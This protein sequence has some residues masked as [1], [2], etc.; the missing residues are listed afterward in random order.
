MVSLL[1]KSF[2]LTYHKL[3]CHTTEYI[4][5]LYRFIGLLQVSGVLVPDKQVLF[6]F[7]Y[8]R[9]Y[10]HLCLQMLSQGSKVLLFSDPLPISKNGRCDHVK[11]KKIGMMLGGYCFQGPVYI[12][13]YGKKTV[14]ISMSAT[15][16]IVRNLNLNV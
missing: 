7:H 10:W 12:S 8:W 6:F 9:Y 11:Q 5:A 15:Q 2:W 14:R 13:K 1:N 4:L 3:A 16:L